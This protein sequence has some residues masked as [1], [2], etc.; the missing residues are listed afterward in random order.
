MPDAVAHPRRH[1]VLLED[2]AI[3]GRFVGVPVDLMRSTVVAGV[4]IDGHDRG[5]FRRGPGEDDRRLSAE[6]ADLD[7]LA[8]DRTR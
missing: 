1:Q 5:T 6:A 2:H 8:V 7:D 4:R 3:G